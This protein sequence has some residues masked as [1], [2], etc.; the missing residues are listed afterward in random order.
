VCC[1]N[2]TRCLG[3]HWYHLDCVGLDAIPGPTVKWYC[4]YC[5]AD[6]PY[7]SGAIEGPSNGGSGND[8]NPDGSAPGSHP[9]HGR[10]QISARHSDPE[11][12]GSSPEPSHPDSMQEAEGQNIEEDSSSP[13]E[14]SDDGSEYIENTDSRPTNK[15]G[16]KR[17]RR[18]DAEDKDDLEGD[19][20]S[21]R[22]SKRSRTSSPQPSKNIQT[23]N[24]HETLEEPVDD[25][26]EEDDGDHGSQPQNAPC[27]TVR[28][29]RWKKDELEAAKRAMI[30]SITGDGLPGDLE[31]VLGDDRFHQASE[32][33]KREGVYRAA[34]A[35]R[36]RWV[37]KGMREDAKFD[38]R[39]YTKIG[40]APGDDEVWTPHPYVKQSRGN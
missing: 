5:I 28:G 21:E 10:G 33:L 15:N 7:T 39:L 18:E 37:K 27:T 34:G 4:Y 11:D 20:L 1:E 14:S 38:E 26:N 24:K 9:G 22:S 3:H 32:I 23:S 30:T 17:R 36:A 2:L 16:M 29:G 12:E 8:S 25:E 40:V 6:H 13:Q 31:P 35:I 19:E